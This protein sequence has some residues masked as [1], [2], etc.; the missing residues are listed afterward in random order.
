MQACM[1]TDCS[2]IFHVEIRGEGWKE[3]CRKGTVGVRRLARNLIKLY[4]Y[5][6]IDEIMFII[7]SS[8]STPS[9]LD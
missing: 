1:L 3:S 7:E 2:R 5:S 9:R 4:S 6:S 8:I